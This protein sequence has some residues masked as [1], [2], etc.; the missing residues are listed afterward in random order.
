[1]L[2]QQIVGVTTLNTF[3]NGLDRLRKTKISFFTD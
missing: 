2:D 1:M 3:K